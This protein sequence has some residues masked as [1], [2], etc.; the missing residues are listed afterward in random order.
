M[1]TATA[2]GFVFGLAWFLFA[3]PTAVF[4]LRAYLRSKMRGFLWLFLALAAW[5][6]VARI[7]TFVVEAASSSLGL[8]PN[9]SLGF[10]HLP[11]YLLVPFLEQIL[12]DAL[13]LYAVVL[14]DRELVARL[15]P[16]RRAPPPPSPPVAGV[17]P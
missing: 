8:L 13:L 15:L 4:L 2:I 3:V 16:A 12:G 10:V 11:G 17:S 1:N 14:L 7:L 5:P 6:F 9:L